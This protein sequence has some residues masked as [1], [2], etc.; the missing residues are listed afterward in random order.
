M[1]IQTTRETI[2]QMPTATDE[3][4]ATLHSRRDRIVF[5]N[6]AGSVKAVF[7]NRTVKDAIPYPINGATYAVPHAGR[8]LNHF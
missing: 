4:Q 5:V 1:N 7:V 6:V 3:R 2:D 8:S